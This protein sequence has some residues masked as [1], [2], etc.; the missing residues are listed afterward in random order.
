[1]NLIFLFIGLFLLIFGAEII[2]RGSVSL[3]KKLKVSPTHQ[4]AE[5]NKKKILTPHDITEKEFR[6]TIRSKKVDFIIV[7][8]N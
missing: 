4:W 7:H 1:M 2:I 5:K 6:E 3:G 8:R